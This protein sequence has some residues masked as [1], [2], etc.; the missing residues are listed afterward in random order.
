[1]PVDLTKPV[2][3]KDG[4]KVRILATDLKRS[5]YPV[6]AAVMHDNG[7]ESIEQYTADGHFYASGS[8]SDE[9]LVNV[10]EPQI[11]YA[12]LY[13]AGLSESHAD[14]EK[15]RYNRVSTSL[16]IMK[17]TVTGRKISAEFVE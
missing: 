16:G 1:M 13:R 14:L 3:T 7:K 8:A 17:I 5:D 2:E 15:A 9:D 4:R 6:V 11:I 10:P 12:N